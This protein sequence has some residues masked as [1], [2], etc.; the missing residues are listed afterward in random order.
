MAAYFNIILSRL[1]TYIRRP[2]LRSCVVDWL[3]VASAHHI[4]HKRTSF[5]AISSLNRFRLQ[6]EYPLD[7]QPL[8]KF[9][10]PR[11]LSPQTSAVYHPP[12]LPHQHALALRTLFSAQYISSTTLFHL[13]SPITSLPHLPGCL[14]QNL[15]ILS[16]STGNTLL[17]LGFHVANCL[18]MGG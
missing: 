17:N 9:P 10:K 8:T 6:R 7:A 11:L 1:P 14:S 12:P 15:Q 16:R 18:S 2:L 5:L 13:L 3:L 4:L